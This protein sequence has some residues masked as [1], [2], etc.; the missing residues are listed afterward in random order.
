MKITTKW[1]IGIIIILFLTTAYFNRTP[2]QDGEISTPLVENSSN[3]TWVTCVNTE[4]N[5][6]FTYPSEYFVYN[7]A[8]HIR[9]YYD[10]TL[11][12]AVNQTVLRS[13]RYPTGGSSSDVLSVWITSI[14]TLPDIRPDSSVLNSVQ[15][16]DTTIVYLMTSNKDSANME[17]AESIAQTLLKIN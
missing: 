8:D 10:K 1:V 7:S 16:N 13:K 12:C 6:S 2:S 15:L 17:I 4:Y 14:S 3:D 5:F 9:A 11:D